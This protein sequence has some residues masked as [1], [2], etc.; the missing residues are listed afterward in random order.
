MAAPD[1]N[2]KGKYIEDVEECS[3]LFK[4]ECEKNR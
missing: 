1:W 2:S 3:W 4:L